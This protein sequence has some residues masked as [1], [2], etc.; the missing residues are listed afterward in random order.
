MPQKTKADPCSGFLAGAASALYK[1]GGLTA[2]AGQG[3]VILGAVIEAGDITPA[4]PITA[5]G[6]LAVAGFGALGVLV[7]TGAQAVAG[8]Y[9][10]LH[11]NPYPLLNSIASLT[12]GAVNGGSGVNNEAMGS[13]LDAEADAV[14]RG[15]ERKCRPMP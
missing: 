10:A 6:G 9:Y 7:G 8:T 4:V 5:P 14:E 11:G 1:G 15:H 3:A 2:K 12:F 13:A